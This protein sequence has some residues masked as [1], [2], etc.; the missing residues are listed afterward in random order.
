MKFFTYFIFVAPL[1]FANPLPAPEIQ[2]KPR[3]SEKTRAPG[4]IFKRERNCMIV[5]QPSISV[6]NCR[7]GPG[8]NYPVIATLLV[9]ETYPF[10]CRKV[11]QCLDN[12]VGGVD[13]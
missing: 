4:N 5:N 10:K 11:G 13:W 3:I 12:N 1:A 9:G 6:V 7:S 2:L 8:T